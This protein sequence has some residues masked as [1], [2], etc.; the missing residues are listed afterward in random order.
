[1]SFFHKIKEAVDREV[2]KLDEGIDH[3][4]STVEG[5]FKELVHDC[6]GTDKYLA[7]S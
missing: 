1:M 5:A 2:Q 3:A 4:R 7:L 6:S